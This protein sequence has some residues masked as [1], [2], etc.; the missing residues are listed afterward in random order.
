MLPSGKNWNLYKFRMLHHLTDYLI[1]N[2]TPLVLLQ[3]VCLQALKVKYNV[4]CLFTWFQGQFFALVTLIST[5]LSHWSSNT[6]TEH[7]AMLWASH[8]LKHVG[9]CLKG[10]R[11][12]GEGGGNDTHAVRHLLLHPWLVP[13][14]NVFALKHTASVCRSSS[15]DWKKNQNRTEPNCK[16]PDHWL[17]LPWLWKFPVASCLVCWNLERPQ[18]TGPNWLQLVFYL[19]TKAHQELCRFYTIKSLGY[20]VIVYIMRLW[21]WVETIIHYQTE[22]KT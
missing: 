16:R 21:L 18:K 22:W 4:H 20:K 14:H 11:V 3:S 15:L 5:F 2:Q 17:Q 12:E 8:C 13:T 6:T 9:Q 7:A 10:S 1:H 19:C